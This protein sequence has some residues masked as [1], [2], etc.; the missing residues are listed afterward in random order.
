ML[1]RGQICTIAKPAILRAA[2]KA[3]PPYVCGYPSTART[4][5]PAPKHSA[6]SAMSRTTPVTK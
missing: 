1:I 2:P 4:S 5:R 3:N 6:A